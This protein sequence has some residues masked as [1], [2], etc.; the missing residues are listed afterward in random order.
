VV[1]ERD[2]VAVDGFGAVDVDAEGGEGEIVSEVGK[3]M[4]RGTEERTYWQEAAEDISGGKAGQGS[5]TV[6]NKKKKKA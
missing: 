6:A 4:Q 1:V 5:I 3:A 2:R